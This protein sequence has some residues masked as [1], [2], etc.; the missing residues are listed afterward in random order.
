MTKDERQAIYQEIE[1]LSI[2]LETQAPEMG[3]R[4][5]MERMQDCRRAQDRVVDLCVRVNREMSRA[6]MDLRAAQAGVTM[7]ADT[8]T[9]IEFRDAANRLEAEEMDLRLL[10]KSL[11]VRRGNLRGMAQDIRTIT[12]LMDDQ[13]GLGSVAPAEEA[14]EERPSSLAPRP[15]RANR[16]RTRVPGPAAPPVEV[17]LQEITPLVVPSPSAS[18]DVLDIDA[19]MKG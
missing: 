3:P 6:R 19:F 5:Y 8:A 9:M 4:Y 2:R 15:Q 10:Y 17:L 18:A 12:K 16:G 1:G 11:E 7:A 13:R 14:G